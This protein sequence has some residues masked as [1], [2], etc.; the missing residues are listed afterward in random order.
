[1]GR[2]VVIETGA[3]LHLGF[4]RLCALGNRLLGG[5]GLAVEGAHEPVGVLL[6][7]AR[8]GSKPVAEGCDS[9]RAQAFLEEAVSRFKLPSGIYVRLHRC[10]PRH[11][12]LGSTTQL[13]LAIYSA[14]AALA[15]LSVETAVHA[16]SRS[17][18][19]GVGTGVFLYGGL[20]V[21]AGSRDGVA[22]PMLWGS[23]PERWGIVAVIPRTDWRVEEGPGEV[24]AIE[25]VVRSL[26]SGDE[27]RRAYP[28]V[29]DMLA[30]GAAEG[31]F[32]LFV[33]GVELLERKAAEAFS[34]SQGGAFCCPEAEEAAKALRGSG[35]R[36][37]GQSSWGPLVYGFYPSIE[38]AELAAARIS[39]LLPYG[40]RV[41]VLRPRSRGAL[42]AT[43]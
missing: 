31:D 39:R 10:L 9:E 36:G 21:D 16:A 17:R 41:L 19:S 23:V 12:G 18:F 3:R 22:R 5:V 8:T 43:F 32:E 1:L 37:V 13:A 34:G 33:K 14:V 29:L 4:Y 26:P 30:P 25:S 35:A 7:A 11:V 42:I 2:R 27:C 6:E 40:W 28:V 20:V 38:D 15:G 24:E